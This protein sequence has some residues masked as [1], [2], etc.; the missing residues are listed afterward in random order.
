MRIVMP[1]LLVGFFLPGATHAE[2]MPFIEIDPTTTTALR[3]RTAEHAP[4]VAVGVNY[5]DPHT[6]WAPKIWKAFDEEHTRKHLTMLREQG[7]NTIR[8]FLTLDSFHREPGRLHAEGE[9]K[10]RTLLSLCREQNIYVIPSGPDHWEGVPAWRGKD[11]YADE[12]ILAADETWWRVFAE[13]FKDEAAILAYDLLNEP[14][15]RWDTPT[16]QA[17]WNDWLRA[18]YAATED[19]ARAWNGA[20]ES[21]EAFGSI[22][23]PPPN[24]APGSQRLYDYQLFRESI[25]D[26]WTRRHAAA[27]RSVDPNHLI[28]V[29]HI[30]WAAPIYYPGIQHYAGFNLA[31]NA[32]HVDFVTIHFYPLDEPKPCDGPEGIAANAKYLEALLH[33]CSVGKPVMLGEFAWYGGGEIRV[34][35]RLQMPAQTLEDQVAWG[36]ALLDVTQGRVC[37]W[38]HWAFADT[39]TS[40]DLTRWS[41]CWTEDLVLKPWGR[42]YGEFARTA[43]R[44]PAERRPFPPDITALPV[45]RKAMLTDP[46]AGHAYRR[47]LRSGPE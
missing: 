17:Q 8:V 38:L 34:N 24:P 5:F 1:L 33:P 16:M 27:I 15:I 47:R 40:N 20:A 45:D 19:I 23:V 12:T 41:G 25:A 37:G 3:Q 6:G 7:F 28:T 31:T 2:P 30:Q 46:A 9:R 29:G 39:P 10:F 14:S 13:R 42:L 11:P 32:K 43:T 44:A 36:R 18:K 26:A 35:G 21:V 4:F 22:A